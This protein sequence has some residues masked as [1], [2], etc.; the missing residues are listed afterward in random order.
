MTTYVII[1]IILFM[2]FFAYYSM[3]REAIPEEVMTQIYVSSVNPG[4]SAEDVEKFI[5]EPLEKEFNNVARVKKIT[6]TTHQYFS[7]IIV[8]FEDNVEIANAKQL[9]KDRVDMVK[10]ETTWPTL[11]NGRSEERR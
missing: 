1:A 3:T 8:E 6:S 10:A 5:T 2:G 7:I 4:N 9:V 11:D